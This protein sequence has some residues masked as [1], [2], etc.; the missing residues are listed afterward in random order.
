M[1]NSE[2]KLQHRKDKLVIEGLRE[3]LRKQDRYIAKT[4]LEQIK[5]TDT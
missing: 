2:Y 1:T 3:S 4:T 5:R